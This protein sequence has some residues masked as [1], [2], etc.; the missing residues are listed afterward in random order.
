M[1]NFKKNEWRTKIHF[2]KK[3]GLSTTEAAKN[4]QFH[5][6]DSVPDRSTVSRWMGRFSSDR[7]SLEDDQRRGAPTTAMTDANINLVKTVLNT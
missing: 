5:Y 2:L 1:S 4:F 7:Q 3:E 6:G